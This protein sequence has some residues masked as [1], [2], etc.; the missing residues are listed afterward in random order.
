MVTSAI[1]LCCVLPALKGPDQSVKFPPTRL[2]VIL[3]ELS[4]SYGKELACA[5]DFKD[6]VL[7]AYAPSSK[8]ENLLQHIAYVTDGI[9]KENG[10]SGLVLT[11]DPESTRIEDYREFV[12]EDW[13]EG[14]DRL[15]KAHAAE[16]DLN[17]SQKIA[18]ELEYL[19]ISTE[20]MD[21][22]RF[23]TR[24]AL[25]SRVP[26]SRLALRLVRQIIEN[27]PEGLPIFDSYGSAYTSKRNT[28][29]KAIKVSSTDLA[30]FNRAQ[31]IWNSFAAQRAATDKHGAFRQTSF[32]ASR[33]SGEG[34]SVFLLFQR[35]S[36]FAN[37]RV[38][39][40]ITDRNGDIVGTSVFDIP[41]TMRQ[42]YVDSVRNP[43]VSGEPVSFTAKA[44]QYSKVRSITD[45]APARSIGNRDLYNQI[46]S[47]TKSEPLSFLAGEVLEQSFA[48]SEQPYVFEL[49][50]AL[51]HLIPR[52]VP[53]VLRKGTVR[54]ALEHRYGAIVE[55]HKDHFVTIRYSNPRKHVRNYPRQNLETIADALDRKGSLSL[56][57]IVE[58]LFPGD[59]SAEDPLPFDTARVIAPGYERMLQQ[60]NEAFPRLAGGLLP[61]ERAKLLAGQPLLVSQ[62]SKQGRNALNELL[63][64]YPR[65]SA[66]VLIPHFAAASTIGPLVI[67]PS[68]VTNDT[69]IQLELK[70]A[71]GMAVFLP[72]AGN[73]TAWYTYSHYTQAL[74]GVGSRMART[75]ELCKIW[76]GEFLHGWLKFKR[77]GETILQ[78]RVEIT[79]VD[80]R[81]TPLVVNDLTSQEQEIVFAAKQTEE[82]RIARELARKKVP[83]PSS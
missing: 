19:L 82:A 81:Q 56:D 38:A 9:W 40:A 8:T 70:K 46:L 7:M 29:Y 2:E 30:E 45:E 10:P 17:E 83:P 13:L 31:K 43:I 73:H 75:D 32:R 48:K 72:P 20:E 52:S 1:M 3:K 34:E 5:K 68:G 74:I 21:P 58:Q 33:N 50:D 49:H 36:F 41:T 35:Y 26:A 55:D 63:Y 62:I 69:V 71:P 79:E 57:E 76:R 27:S 11:S 47:P 54:T 80:T 42:R 23:E 67:Y 14:L 60:I 51:S 59:R 37:P 4:A 53:L 66:D 61:Q 15:E 16:F 78:Y 12:T 28:A 39:I 65:V 24:Y 44:I 18:S 64:R 77:D 22:R 25:Q 6:R